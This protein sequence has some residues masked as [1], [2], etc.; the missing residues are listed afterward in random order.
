MLEVLLAVMNPGHV[1]PEDF[2]M[3]SPPGKLKWK[4]CENM[5]RYRHSG[6]K[7]LKIEK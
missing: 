6:W 2:K 5:V 4:K 7:E 1:N 3:L